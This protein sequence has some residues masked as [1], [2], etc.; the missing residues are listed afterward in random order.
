MSVN[1]VSLALLLPGGSP[2]PHHYDGS[3]ISMLKAL[4]LYCYE[5]YKT[6]TTGLTS[7]AQTF[8]RLFFAVLGQSAAPVI[9]DCLGLYKCDA[10]ARCF[11]PSH[12]VSQ[13]LHFR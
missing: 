2:N 11:T 10:L 12:C 5:R 8:R 3:G 4:R 9:V 6:K 1:W 13:T 7:D